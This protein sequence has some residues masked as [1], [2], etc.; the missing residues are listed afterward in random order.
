MTI[1]VHTLILA[2]YACR[3]LSLV[4]LNHTPGSM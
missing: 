2:K 4:T 3:I 1:L